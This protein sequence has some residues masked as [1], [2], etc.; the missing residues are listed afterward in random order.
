MIGSILILSYL[1]TI[2]AYHH[3]NNVIALIS[4]NKCLDITRGHDKDKDLSLPHPSFT[5][6]LY[7][8]IDKYMIYYRV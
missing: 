6:I 4:T 1:P 3:L 5:F 2:C 8:Y 7:L